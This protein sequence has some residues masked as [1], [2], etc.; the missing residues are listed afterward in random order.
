MYSSGDKST[1]TKTPASQ[2][3]RRRLRISGLVQGVGFRPFVYRLA[4][5]LSL[6]GFVTNDSRGVTIEIEGPVEQINRFRDRLNT[7]LPPLAKI[8]RCVIE[9]VPFRSERHFVVA[10]TA[11]NE[12]ATAS[13]CPDVALCDDCLTELRDPAN[14]RFHYPFI[15]CTNC[16]P[17]F[18]IVTHIP[19]DRPG[20]TMHSFPMCGA[21][22]V[23]YNDPGDRRFQAQ[24]IAC[25]ECGPTVW[26]HD[27]DRMLPSDNPIRAAGHALAEGKIVAIRG[28][29]GFHLA[30]DAS[31]DEAVRRLR[32]RKLRDQ[33]PFALMA[34]DFATVH[35]CCRATDEELE[36]VGSKERPIVLLDRL[37]FAPVAGSVAPGCGTLGL[38]LPYT[39]LHYLLFDH[40]PALLVMTSGNTSDEPIAIGNEEAIV[41]LRDIA[42]LF[43]L[44]NRE[45]EQ[46]CDDSVTR[47]SAGAA[48]VIRRS[49]GLAPSPIVLQHCFEKSV[50][51][52][53]PE[54]KNT[55]ALARENLVTLSQH[56]GDLDNPSALKQF[57]STIAHLC[58]VLQ[59]TPELIACDLH[60]AYHATIWAHRR[61]D[62]PVIEI[63]H[64]H[65]HLCSV[66]A[67]NGVSEPTIGVILDGTGY[68]T[69]GTVWGGE[70]LIGDY[71]GFDRFAWL[72][73]TP[74]LGG[75][76][77]VKEPWRMALS[78]LWTYRPDHPR[79]GEIATEQGLSP[80][81]LDI[82]RRLHTG[83]VNS[84]LTSSCGRLFDAVAAL[85]GVCSVNAFEAQAA[86]ALET[87]A[88]PEPLP[89]SC[90]WTLDHTPTGGAIS[91][92]EL[93]D[94]L[95][96]D[97]DAGLE[98]RKIARRIHA[99]IGEAM[100]QSV[101]AARSATGIGRVGLSGG[102]FQ[103][104]LLYE[105]MVHRLTREGFDVL[106]HSQVP[107]NDG[108]L[109][110]G[111]AIAA[112]ARYR[113]DQR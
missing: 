39:P 98:Q 30:V 36:R 57:E 63:Q 17:R 90:E 33:K 55:I 44:H 80:D 16:G 19:Y 11:D 113:A 68:G 25:S 107:T 13:I 56:I 93:L 59:F 32:T 27:R 112:D 109:V 58:S 85:A 15:N 67:E 49:R 51:A 103:N 69:D 14:R 106:S 46:R 81:R 6:A 71:H 50:L 8:D 70:I 1:T 92:N 48:R 83:R 62:L 18:T 43:L 65:A 86:M 61:T 78:Y 77:A 41:R 91:L 20:T 24:P 4:T 9:A 72:Q 79:I 88:G 73:P 26:L 38:M 28:L 35:S 76:A 105:F 10:D 104:R 97:I 3:E 101:L 66:M 74:L 7:S 64:H 60:P 29:G 5:E 53:G 34:R 45:I 96:A 47:F 2:N 21:C 82:L 95:L 100:I 94:R 102:V 22:A 52:C 23:E 87:A 42:D 108:G 31:N 40:S 37:T 84:P 111:Q 110:L 99:W 89:E 75:T 12:S 54:M